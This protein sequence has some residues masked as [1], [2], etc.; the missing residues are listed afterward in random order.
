MRREA[1]KAAGHDGLRP[2][3]AASGLTQQG[4]TLL[5]LLVVV[6]IVGVLVTFATLSISNRAVNDKLETEAKRLQ[7]L[8]EIA[9]EDAELQGIEIGFV[10]TPQGYLFVAAQDQQWL[11]LDEGPLRA[12]PLPPPMRLWVQVDGREAAPLSEAGLQASIKAARLARDAARKE[13]SGETSDAALDPVRFD[14]VAA[15]KD[16]EALKPQILFLSSGEASD[17]VVEVSAPGADLAY[18]LEIDRLGRI[19]RSQRT[20][21]R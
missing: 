14:N 9:G 5:E 18:R 12:R 15:E 11:P 17:A 20:A 7:Q 19:T 6:V 10:F 3:P 13:Q 16:R 4:F 8:F 1:L 2:T 21:A